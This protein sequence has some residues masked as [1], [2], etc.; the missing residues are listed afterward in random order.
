MPEM[1]E[2]IHP[3]HSAC[4]IDPEQ[5]QD[6]TGVGKWTLRSRDEHGIYRVCSKRNKRAEIRILRPALRDILFIEE[7]YISS[8]RRYDYQTRTTLLS[9]RFNKIRNHPLFF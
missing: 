2:P 9:E 5:I 8:G 4:H 3:V 1:P 7:A 6:Y